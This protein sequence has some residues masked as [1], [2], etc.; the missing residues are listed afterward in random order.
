MRF[1]RAAALEKGLAELAE[2]AH[3][4]DAAMQALRPAPKPVKA[5]PKV[6]PREEASDLSGLEARYVGRLR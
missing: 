6:M 2:L 4:M 3:R 1:A 5:A